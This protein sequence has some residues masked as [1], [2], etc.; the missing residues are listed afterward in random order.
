MA[1]KGNKEKKIATLLEDLSM[2]ESYSRE[3]FSFTPLPL[4][5]VSSK[6]VILEANPS[7]EE[8]TGRSAYEIVGEGVETIFNKKEI[9]DVL[10]ETLKKGLIRDKEIIIFNKKGE[11]IPVSLFSQTRKT[12][13]GKKIGCFFGLFDLTETKKKEESLEGSKQV[14]EIRVAAKT[15]ELRELADE[16]EKKV[17]D[18]TRE[19]E[20]KVDELERINKLMVGR[21]IK[22]IE[23]KENLEVAQKKI[24]KL[25]EDK[26]NDS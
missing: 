23:L 20:E 22:M 18:R 14:L 21:E 16:L 6:G 4:F 9:N 15:K 10:K 5:F 12:K 19:L 24:E 26:D 13:S 17:E 8:I 1:E 7:L 11:G 2:L 25:K 3:L